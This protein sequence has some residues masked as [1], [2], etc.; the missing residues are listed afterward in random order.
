MFYESKIFEIVNKIAIGFSPDK[1]ILFGFYQADQ[2]L[3]SALVI[4]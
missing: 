3:G 4:F 2:D 1:I